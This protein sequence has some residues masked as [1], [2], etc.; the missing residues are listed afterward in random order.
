M[1]P[2]VMPSSLSPN[3]SLTLWDAASSH[4]TLNVMTIAAIIF[5]PTVLG[6]TLW[7][8]RSLWAKISVEYIQDNDY[9]SY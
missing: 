2:F 5:V 4:L 6:Y 1:F 9:S 3:S 8:Y 7:C